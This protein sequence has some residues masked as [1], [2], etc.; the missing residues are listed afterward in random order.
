M[1]SP[2][3][4][5]AD[6]GGP[7]MRIGLAAD[8]HLDCRLGRLTDAAGV[9]LRSL[10][11]EAATERVVDG[12]IRDQVDAVAILG[13]LFDIPRPSERS[14]Q[15]LVRAIRRLAAG[16][17]GAPIILMRGNHDA[18]PGFLA[19][20]AVGTTALALPEV[21]V[22]DAYEVRTVE[23]A[24]DVVLTLIPWMR[25]DEEFLSAIFGLDPVPGKHNLLLLHCGLADLPEFA[26]SRPGSQ[27]LT[28]ALLPEGFEEIFSGHFH[29]H[30]K[31][32]GLHFTFIGSPE[33]LSVSEATDPKG[34]CIYDTTKR[35]LTFRPIT[36]RSWYDPEVIDATGLDA[37]AIT[38]KVESLISALPDYGQAIVRLRVR[39]VAPEVR[40]ALDWARLTKLRAA[41]FYCDL[42]IEAAD[43]N[44]PVSGADLET[45]PTDGP[46]LGDLVGEWEHWVGT[47]DRDPVERA[48]LARL[49]SDALIAAA[50]AKS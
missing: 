40:P 16:L 34:Y 4:P 46:I 7:L 42:Q 19:G 47:L 2:I 17:P 10:D 37:A 20:T 28:R 12:L 29:G 22:A 36:T 1:G 41:A 48:A 32:P 44:A 50:G 18:A 35:K 8:L 39:R 33:R 49:G 5:L 9:N 23:L 21:I 43:A 3:R 14:R 45:D 25:S 38:E 31:F 30:H 24:D 26:E 13:D 11:F 15:A 27:V 6:H